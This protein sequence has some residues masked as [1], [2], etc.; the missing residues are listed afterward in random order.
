MGWGNYIDRM[1]SYLFFHD[2]IIHSG[3][4]KRK[5]YIF[6]NFPEKK[7]LKKKPLLRFFVLK[8][9]LIWIVGIKYWISGIGAKKN[10]GKWW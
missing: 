10:Q 8:T 3:V 4:I 7:K 2:F 6:T 5:I 9:D 1:Q